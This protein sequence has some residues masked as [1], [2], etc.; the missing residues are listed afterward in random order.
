ME[1][2]QCLLAAALI[3]TSTTNINNQCLRIPTNNRTITL[4]ICQL[5]SNPLLILKAKCLQ[6][7]I[8][9]AIN[10]IRCKICSNTTQAC[11]STPIVARISFLHLL[12]SLKTS[13]K[14]NLKHSTNTIRDPNSTA[15]W[16]I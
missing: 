13:S 8:L 16:S 7:S 10:R 14:D 15:A 12:D 11:L 2:C 3:I 5:V 6:G 1:I 4:I 9:I